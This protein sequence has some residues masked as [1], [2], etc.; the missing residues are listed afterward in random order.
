VSAI[1]GEPDRPMSDLVA[2]LVAR[3]G[4]PQRLRVVGI[5]REDFRA[6]AEHTMHDPPVRANPRPITSADDLV[7]ILEL[8]W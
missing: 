1:L 8:A 7:E 2:A 6:I 3:L 5:K 4:L